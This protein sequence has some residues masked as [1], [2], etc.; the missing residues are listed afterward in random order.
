VAR[1][2]TVV[3]P[4]API[5]PEIAPVLPLRERLEGKLVAGTEN[6]TPLPPR[7]SVA[8]NSVLVTDERVLKVTR[9][10]PAAGE[11]QVTPPTFRVAALVA[12]RP[13]PFV[14]TTL[15]GLFATC[16]DAKVPIL[17]PIETEFVNVKSVTS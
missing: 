17:N 11:V 16:P 9:V 15:K 5:V 10:A 14:T 7:S 6:V 8:A 2:V 12:V 1:N 4:T 3:V 13:A